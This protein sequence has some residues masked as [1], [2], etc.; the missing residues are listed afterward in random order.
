VGSHPASLFQTNPEFFGRNIPR[1][2]SFP[3]SRQPTQSL[4]PTR[5][6]PLVS[7]NGRLSTAKPYRK[8]KYCAAR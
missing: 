1:D 8:K 4:P 3:V 6:V 5:S 2:S 7:M